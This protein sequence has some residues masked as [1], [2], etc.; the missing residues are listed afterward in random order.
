MRGNGISHTVSAGGAGALT[1]AAVAN[2]PSYANV[3]G[4]TGSRLVEYVATEGN[5]MECGLGTL[6]LAT[7][8]L[9]RTQIEST[10][11]GSVY[12][13]NASLGASPAALTFTTAATVIC[14]PSAQSFVRAASFNGAFGNGPVGLGNG[15]ATVNMSNPAENGQTRL[16]GWRIYFP[17]L[18]T[19]SRPIVSMTLNINL[20]GTG[21]LLV[22]LMEMRGN[23]TLSL[24]A[25]FTASSPIDA[26]VLGNA[27][28]SV[29][30]GHFAPVYAPAGPYVVQLV[31]TGGTT[32]G[33]LPVGYYMSAASA[34]LGWQA[35]PPYQPAATMLD[36][37]G[38]TR[39]TR[40]S[41][42]GP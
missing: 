14:A 8:V 4:S 33:V 38:S 29:A 34:I 26:T 27:T 13:T 17:F 39:P 11:T 25:D 9:T 37:A 28:R 2:T 35:G 32:P 24:I 22:G 1:L 21:T 10:W 12:A 15:Y 18:W 3:F 19:G 16:D 40:G 6:A 41:R 23:S 7:G 30:S 20:A 36:S 5:T 31:P 42:P